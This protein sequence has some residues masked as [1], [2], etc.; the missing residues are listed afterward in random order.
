VS[1]APSFDGLSGRA[2]DG[3]V[4][5]VG[6]VHGELEAL[7]DLLRVLGYHADGEH[8]HGRRLIFI[9]DLCD[10]GPDSPGVICRV[11][12]LVEGG[13]AQCLLGNHEL[14]LL[15]GRTKQANG[16]FFERDHDRERGLFEDSVPA[17]GQTER[18]VII[19]FLRTLPLVLERD[20]LRL[21]HACWIDDR[22]AEIRSAAEAGAVDLY[23]RHS[24]HAEEIARD[25]G[26]EAEATALL[27]FYG[28][29]LYDRSAHVPMLDALA[30]RDLAYQLS[31]PVR[32]LTSG[33]EQRVAAPFYMAGKW[34][35]VERAAW[36]NDYWSDVPVFFGHYW[37]W[38]A[39]DFGRRYG[40]FGHNPFPRTAHD[41]WL[42]PRASAFC[43]DFSVGARYTERHK[44]PGEPFTSRLGAVRWPERELL[45]DNGS[46]AEL[47]A[48]PPAADR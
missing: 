35:M 10:R 42:G 39:P 33:I 27:E 31:N 23:R 25:S 6:D 20:D 17:A 9:G 13:A 47:V 5:I 16:W 43:V 19:D 36:W 44:W 4:D 37:R 14:S 24:E 30:E 28:D 29:R 38:P 3:P 26:L 48:P 41:Q 15:R 2:F 8:P 12:A 22:V 46:G 11:R 40:E 1:G 45:F 21:V 32:V 18:A 7:E 34:R